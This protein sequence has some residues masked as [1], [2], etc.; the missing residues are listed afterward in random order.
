MLINSRTNVTDMNYQLVFVTKYRKQMFTTPELKNKLKTILQSIAD[1]KGVTIQSIE[2]MSDHV[3]LLITFPPKLAA[4]DVVKSFKGSSAREWFKAFP[5]DRKRVWNGHLWSNTFFMN[6]IGNVNEDI[7]NQ[8][9]KN[10]M[11][12]SLEA[13][14]SQTI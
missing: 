5:N 4:S 13:K 10:Q 2:I 9:I 8:Y 7:V 11:K 1:Y 3:S 6:T 12:N 14:Q